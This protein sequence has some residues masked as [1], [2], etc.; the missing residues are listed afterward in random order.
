MRV[1]DGIHRV[2][3]AAARGDKKIEAKIYHG[4]DDDAFVLAVWMNIAHGLPLTHADRT[5]AAARII[6]SHPQWS[7]RRIATVT[8]LAAGTV[9][10][11]RRRLTVQNAQSVTRV[12]K[13]GRV[14]PINSAAGRLKASELLAEKPTAS[15]RAIAKEAGVSPST[16]Y[17]VRRR[18]HA[19]QQ[20][21]TE[22]Q[23]ATAASRL[24]DVRPPHRDS[25]ALKSAGSVNVAAVL[26][27]LKKDPSLQSSDVGRSLLQW[28]ER[29]ALGMAALGKI[30]KTVP[31]HCTSSVAKLARWYAR[32]WSEV[33][34]ELEKR[35]P[36][37]SP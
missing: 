10:R 19:G 37:R 32:G 34:T 31:D 15:I 14:R 30:V 3:A 6:R 4:K 21:T 9:G 2:R 22:R 11:V 29:Y 20:P 12:G 25:G 36:H 27:N 23:R 24:S 33:A 1:I 13:D 35:W 8:G 28:L 16:V 17:E 26:T 7:D 5:A 18:L